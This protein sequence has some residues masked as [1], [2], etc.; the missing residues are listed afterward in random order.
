MLKNLEVLLK[1]NFSLAKSKIY[2]TALLSFGQISTGFL[3]EFLLYLVNLLKGEYK[4]KVCWNFM[5]LQ[6]V[7][8]KYEVSES[9]MK[10]AFPRTQKSILKKHGI[11][12]IKEGR[13]KTANY[14]EEIE[15]DQRAITMYDEVREEMILS[16]DTLKLMNWDFMCF[17][18]IITTPMLVFRGS[19]EDFLKY[20]GC[21]VSKNNII[22][23]KNALQSLAERE[24]ISYNIDKTNPNYF[25][26]GL[27]RKVEEDMKIGIGMVRNCK[28][29]ADKY[30]KR[31]WIPLLKTW[32]GIELLSTRQ[33]FTIKE[34]SAVTGLSEYQIKDSNKILKESAIFKSSRA[35]A[36]YQ[37]C[38]GL[39][40]DLNQEA[41]YNIPN[42][43]V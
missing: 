33:P 19:Y 7:C 14:I 3:F 10:N 6:E 40:V 39:N 1:S 18:A 32:L 17:L 20:A 8:E 41:F 23:L 24:F 12:I 42:K 30:H 15:D 36:G 38:L 29:L 31:S 35:Y 16:N 13:G 27:Y 34:L 4:R 37:R 26:A 22:E 25:I 28:I 9:S 2:E 43:T 5:T 11:R 21:N